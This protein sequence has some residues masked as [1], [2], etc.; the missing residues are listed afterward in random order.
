MAFGLKYQSDF[1]NTPPFQKL[2]SVKI[3]KD[4]YEDSVISDIRI[5]ELTIESNYSDDNTAIVGKGAKLVL[6]AD[7][8]NLTYLED[9]LLSY[10]R[11]FLC[12]I[13]YDGVI[14]FRGYTL[15]DLN[16]RQLLPYSTVTIQFTDYLH[17]T[18]GKYAATLQPVGGTSNLMSIVQSILTE[19]GLDF[20]IYINSTLFE[21]SMDMTETDTF[22]P[23]VVV[24]NSVFYSD[25]YEYDNVY[26]MV[27]KA[28]HSFSAYIYAFEDKWII[29]R[30]EDITRLG[31]WVSY[32]PDDFE[33]DYSGGDTPPGM[34]VPSMRQAINKQLKDFEYVE[35]SQVIE[36][37]TGLH[38]LI[39]QLMEKLLD[40][41]VFND[42]LNPESI[43]KTLYY[44]PQAGTLDYRTWY[45]HNDFTAI[46]VD[47]DK[48]DINDWIHFTGSATFVK[49]LCYNFAIYFNQASDAEDI[50][51]I[52]YKQSSDQDMSQILRVGMFFFIRLDGGPYSGFLMTLSGP[53][54]S[55]IPFHSENSV[56]IN[57]IGPSSIYYNNNYYNSQ[58]F[59]ISAEKE[60]TWT[61]SKEFDLT[62]SLI[63]IYNNGTTYTQYLYG[64]ASLV[65][66][67]YQRVNITFC[68]PQFSLHST[69]Y[70]IWQY[71][72]MFPDTYLGDI[73]VKMNTEEIDNKITYVLNKNFIKTE[74][75]DLYLF[76][77]MNMNYSNALLEED[78]FTRTN[79]W[80]SENSPVPIPLYEVFAKCKF[81]KYGR[82]IHRLKG[83]ILYDGILKPFAIITDDTI[84][85]VNNEVIKFLLNGYTWDLVSGQYEIEAEEYTEEEV[86][87]DGVTYDSQGDP[88]VELP[89][90]PT[91]LRL[92][93]V[94]LLFTH[95]IQVNWDAVSGGVRGY[96]VERQP[97]WSIIQNTVV[98]GYIQVYAG[99]ATSFL[100]TLWGYRGHI[101][102]D[103]IVYRVCAVDIFGNRG[104]W[105]TE[106]GIF[107][108]S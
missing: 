30:Q 26:D 32:N 75:I 107:W 23:Q 50:L 36:Y 33:S 69:N 93:I 71:G 66:T 28:L 27:N 82:T 63:R 87:V 85:N 105:S 83:T 19:T 10:E 42:W 43:Q 90:A 54:A 45:I 40:T 98:D 29:E 13:E 97:F 22:L 48:N 16:E 101:A 53:L 55:G 35:M 91:G 79:L 106:V 57:L 7:T 67:E 25:S 59:E 80:T 72:H 49:G 56:A 76:D 96:I 2:V 58:V 95:P 77:L 62:N 64:L 78:G 60:K 4:G 37:D 3:Y 14:A 5:S 84:K 15:Y 44:C 21:D 52:S 103:T 11:E 92:R 47:K 88:E 74:E 89:P 100:D 70:S 8:A 6:R 102:I 65:G 18:E 68:Q 104:P 99:V 24:Q 86:I 81:R 17:R 31:D 51:T 41:L 94:N 108:V 46:T 38:T 12:T 73:A 39:L 34:T 9:L 61:F 1:Y 20:P